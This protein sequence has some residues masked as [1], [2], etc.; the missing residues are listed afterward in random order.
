MS[1]TKDLTGERFGR[2]IVL[3]RG[4]KIGKNSSFICLC[5]CGNIK[6]VRTYSLTS[7]KTKS[8]GCLQKEEVSSRMKKNILGQKFG[9]LT[10]V[11][12]VGKSESGRYLYNC[13]CECGGN[14]IVN[15]KY[16]LNNDIKNCGCSNSSVK[17]KL[18]RRDSGLKTKEYTAWSDMKQRCYNKKSLSYKNYG[19]R[20]I[21]VCDRW[22]DEKDGFLNFYNDVG[23]IPI[24]YDID[25]INTNG[26]YEPSNVRVVTHQQNCF[27]TRGTKNSSSKYKGVSWDKNTFKWVARI[28][29]DRKSICIG[30]FLDEDDAADAYNEKALELFGEYVHL[31]PTKKEL[32]KFT[33]QNL[34]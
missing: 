33:K 25:R 32:D 28:G 17:H 21:K 7:G 26:D 4:E 3:N 22:M 15:S 2:L 10:V 24:G 1:K 29:K 27:N 16:L 8:C 5:D 9:K 6:N 18:T 13:V 23:E 19:L 34:K 31:N 14:R 20:G 11:E 12:E 30:Y